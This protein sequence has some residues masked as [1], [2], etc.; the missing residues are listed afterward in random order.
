MPR[1]V[2]RTATY[3]IGDY[4]MAMTDETKLQTAIDAAT[5]FVLSAQKIQREI[6]QSREN[7]ANPVSEYLRCWYVSPKTTGQ[8]RRDSMDLT[9]ALAELRKHGV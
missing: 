7:D 6:Q 3:F 9:R 4:E 8:C 1:I 2:E 5:D